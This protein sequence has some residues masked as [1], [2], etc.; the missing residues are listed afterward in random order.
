MVS[1]KYLFFTLIIFIFYLSACTIQVSSSQILHINIID[2][3]SETTI[4][5]KPGSTVQQ[6][7]SQAGIALGN[8]DRTE[9]P[10]YSTISENTSIN[11]IRVKEEYNIKDIEIPFE[12]QT[13]QNES[14]LL[15]EQRLIQPGKNGYKQV[16]YRKLFE[17]GKQISE[18]VFT[19]T[20]ITD[21]VPE[22]VMV[23][24]TKP[25]NPI[26]IP[27]KIAYIIAGNAWVMAGTT[28]NRTP[29]ITT[30][31]LDGYIFTISYD[32]K[33]LLYS[34]KSNKDTSGLNS[35][36]VVNLEGTKHTPLDLGISNVVGHASWVPGESNTITYSNV[37]PITSAPGWQSNNNLYVLSFTDG[38]SVWRNEKIIDTNGGGQYGW[39][40]TNFY[41][42]PDGS[43]LAYSRP[44]SIGYV[45][46]KNKLLVPT[47]Q[48]F[49]FNSH[50][51]WAWVSNLGWSPDSKRFFYSAH[52]KSTNVSD[53]ESSPD[54]SLA[55]L[56][57][58]DLTTTTIA[59]NI[60]MFANPSPAPI[61]EHG[62]YKI[63]VY[64]AIDPNLSNTSRY[65]LMIM[66]G[67]GSNA[68]I[69]FPADG[70]SGMDPK[71][72]A[73]SPDHPINQPYYLAII[74]EKNLW[75]VDSESGNSFQV[76]G[77]GL[78]DTIDWK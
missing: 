21:A 22:I 67:D 50:S 26:S 15:G 36:W 33:W 4:D 42:S 44:D 58:N 7:L 38:G 62:H 23:G 60:G 12:H 70:S 29:I 78:L 17:N 64:K 74:Y 10:S 45:D 56:N 24:V 46:F 53:P 14:L 76:T 57:E 30:G 2:D 52:I 39:W 49:P 43:T 6:I 34:R 47:T 8:L 65:R 5:I 11:I 35:L 48:V 40:G 51:D 71:R 28:S 31:D 55:S 1:K 69:V 75:L 27:G 66:D 68:K 19:Q 61:T 18:S 41:W 13:I 63:A 37:E 59:E 25:F 32:G 54:F 73:W 3:L 16:T 20:I 9:P 72:I 77:D